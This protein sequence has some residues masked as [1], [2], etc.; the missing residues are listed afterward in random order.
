MLLSRILY[1]LFWKRAIFFFFLFLNSHSF[2]RTSWT[3]NPVLWVQEKE[4]QDHAT[5]YRRRGKWM[6]MKQHLPLVSFAFINSHLYAHSKFTLGTS[7][8]S[9]LHPKQ[10]GGAG[11]FDSSEKEIHALRRVSEHSHTLIRTWSISAGKN[12]YCRVKTGRVGRSGGTGASWTNTIMKA[13]RDGEV[14]FL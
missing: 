9:S 6:F 14:F 1:L 8:R 10:R 11:A 7:T 3:F 2:L 4:K 12:G 5:S 13:F